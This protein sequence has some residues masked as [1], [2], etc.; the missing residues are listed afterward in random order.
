M[1]HTQTFAGTLRHLAMAATVALAGQASA[2]GDGVVADPGTPYFQLESSVSVG[3]KGEERL[4]VSTEARC[5]EPAWVFD[6][7]ELVVTRNRFG[8]V[9]FTALPQPGCTSCDPLTLRWYHEPTGYLAFEVHV[10]RRL[11]NLPCPNDQ[12]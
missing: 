3:S 12:N 7:A 4:D 9:Q 6:H 8:D 11:E 2:A 1:A 5:G 10:Y